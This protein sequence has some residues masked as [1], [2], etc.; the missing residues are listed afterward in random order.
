MATQNP[1]V[2]VGI[3]MGMGM[4]NQYRTLL[5]KHIIYGMPLGHLLCYHHD[6]LQ[7]LPKCNEED[8]CKVLG[9]GIAI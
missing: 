9:V 2:W 7:F 4:G 6:P 3:G 1:W 8:A 5:G